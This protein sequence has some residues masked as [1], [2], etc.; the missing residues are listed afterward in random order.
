M[1]VVPAARAVDMASSGFG[2]VGWGV[3]VAV[4]MAVVVIM[5]VVPG[6]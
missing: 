6:R 5:A 3:A 2:G 4:P 1:V